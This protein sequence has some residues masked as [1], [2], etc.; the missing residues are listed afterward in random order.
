MQSF[1]AT[2]KHVSPS[3]VGREQKPLSTEIII[4]RTLTTRSFRT[5]VDVGKTNAKPGAVLYTLKTARET[6]SAR[7][8]KKK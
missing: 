8:E 5:I 7:K 6:P 1:N 4:L 2:A 3:Q